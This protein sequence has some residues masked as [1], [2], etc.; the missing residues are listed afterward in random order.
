MAE[1]TKKKSLDELKKELSDIQAESDAKKQV[2]SGTA[3]ASS[4]HSGGAATI[5]R[6]RAHSPLIFTS[7]FFIV[8]F[9]P[10]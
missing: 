4:T 2:S 10:S 5:I 6:E 3:S 9:P 1:I 8:P 7:L